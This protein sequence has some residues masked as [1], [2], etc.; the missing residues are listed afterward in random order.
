MSNYG[1][2]GVDPSRLSLVKNNG[3]AISKEA[4]DKVFKN[5]VCSICKKPLKVVNII[6]ANGTCEHR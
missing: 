4:W 5:D 6:K 1:E 2:A 3:R